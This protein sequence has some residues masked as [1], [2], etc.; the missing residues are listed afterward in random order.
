MCAASTPNLETNLSPAS[1]RF[2]F[3]LCC[4]CHHWWV[5]GPKHDT[6]PLQDG[7]ATA[8][9]RVAYDQHPI[10]NSCLIFTCNYSA[11]SGDTSG[12]T[13]IQ[14]TAPWRSFESSITKKNTG[15]RC[16]LRSPRFF[17]Q[18][19]NGATSL[20]NPNL[21]PRYPT[22]EGF[23]PLICAVGM[24]QVEDLPKK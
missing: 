18:E 24:L 3:A 23:G 16:Q 2:K 9:T 15:W 14:S 1:Q 7:W 5:I 10:Y 4:W 21:L 6:P 12:N 20:R 11:Q 19:K 13:L 17:F 8:L 22:S